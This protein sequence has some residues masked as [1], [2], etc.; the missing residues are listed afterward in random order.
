MQVNSIGYLRAVPL[1]KPAPPRPDRWPAYLDI[2]LRE[3]IVPNGFTHRADEDVEADWS[4]YGQSGPREIDD[5][6][7][8]LALLPR[9]AQAKRGSYGLKH[10]AEE[11]AGMYVCN[12]ALLIAAYYAGVR[13]VRC[14]GKS[15]NGVLAI[16]A[17]SRWPEH[18]RERIPSYMV[19]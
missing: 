8:F 7:E 18:V 1:E 12:G 4:K 14:G 15:P 6:V 11:W 13:V 3:R 19:Y 2:A 5:C 9:V 17:S 10:V 16:G